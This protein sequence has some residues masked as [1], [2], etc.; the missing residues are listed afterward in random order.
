MSLAF[1]NF[2]FIMLFIPIFLLISYMVQRKLVLFSTAAVWLLQIRSLFFIF[3]NSNIVMF[4]FSRYLSLFLFNLPTVLYVHIRGVSN[5][6][7]E[8][9]S[10]TGEV[11]NKGVTIVTSTYLWPFPIGAVTVLRATLWVTL[12]SWTSEYGYFNKELYCR[13]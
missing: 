8:V 7:D 13:Y 9:V 2:M 3:H 11:T 10:S 12:T 1:K 4:F 5:C 6:F